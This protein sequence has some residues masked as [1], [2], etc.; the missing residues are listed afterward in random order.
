MRK[1][2]YKRILLKLSGESFLGDIAT[3]I[4]FNR[5]L[6]VAREIK[7]VHDLGRRRR[8]HDRRRQPLP[9]RQGHQ[10][11]HRPG[12]GRPDGHAGHG[13]QRHR[14]AGGP[15]QG[16]G[17]HPPRL[18][19]RDQVR[20]RAVHPPA[21]HPA[22]GE[23]PD[24]HLLGRHRQ[25]LLHDRHGGRPAGPRDR[26][27][28]HLQGDQGRRRLLVRPGDR[29]GGQ[30]VQDHPLHRR[31]QE[32]PQGHGRHGHLALQRQRHAHPRLRPGQGRQHQAGRPGR[33]HR[34][35]RST[36]R[37]TPWSKTCSTI[38]PRR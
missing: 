8:R 17:R 19:H 4:D 11:R 16:R 30:E 36:D 32:E 18:G 20:G 37:G 21:G 33:G 5:A 38:P 14:P 22:H 13:H 26:G 7:E 28:H 12:L 2:A 6:A 3:G 31:P 29:Q 25:P 15:G 1:P 9:R 10:G 23:G 27:R 35:P 34:H 24:H